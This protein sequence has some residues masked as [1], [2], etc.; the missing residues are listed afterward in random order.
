MVPK[1]VQVDS[2]FPKRPQHSSLSFFTGFSQGAGENVSFFAV[3]GG[4]NGIKGL[5]RDFDYSV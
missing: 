1:M 3:V 2:S 4:T 5:F